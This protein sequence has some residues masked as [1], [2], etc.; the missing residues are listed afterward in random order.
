LS[1]I[2]DLVKQSIVYFFFRYF[3]FEGFLFSSHR[4]FNLLS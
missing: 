1:I 2:S 3:T 4:L